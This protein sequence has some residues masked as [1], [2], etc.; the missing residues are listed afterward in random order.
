MCNIKYKI[1]IHALLIFLSASCFICSGCNYTLTKIYGIKQIKLL[2][3]KAIVKSAWKYNIPLSDLYTVDTTF[4]RYLQTRDTSKN[5]Y[6]SK[7][8]LQPL[9]ALYY[10]RNGIFVSYQINCYAGGFPNLD[11]NRN[12]TFEVF[13]PKQQC[14][15]DSL[16]SLQAQLKLIK[17]LSQTL[18]INAGKFDTIVMVY[19]SSFMGRQSRRFIRIIQKNVKL[20]SDKVKV[21]YINTDN[22][23]AEEN[24]LTN[25]PGG[26]CVK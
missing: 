20:T 12:S 16:I 13:P 19:W 26:A 25:C 4:L 9:Q 3:E 24:Y 23:Y 5:K 18:A 1:H 17:P 11:W 15:V 7:N 6:L 2:N 10:T 8:H 14:P 22:L 21:L